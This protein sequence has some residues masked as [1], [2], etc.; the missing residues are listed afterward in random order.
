MLAG[1][2]G[3]R[4]PFAQSGCSGLT[5]KE[6]AFVILGPRVWEVG[7]SLRP[8][9]PSLPG[10]ILPGLG[11]ARLQPE[12]EGKRVPVLR[13]DDPAGPGPP[14]ACPVTSGLCCGQ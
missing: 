7:V 5:R 13:G 3:S 12:A 2:L 8:C 9:P 10:T 11:A 14:P 1:H 6:L 4:V